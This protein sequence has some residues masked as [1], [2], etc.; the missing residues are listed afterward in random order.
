MN[1]VHGGCIIPMSVIVT[2]RCMRHSD[3][4][5]RLSLISATTMKRSMI[6]QSHGR[7]D[8]IVRFKI[9]SRLAVHELQLSCALWRGKCWWGA[10]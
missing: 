4:A 5:F 9:G 8:R 7:Y 2:S 1:Q 6:N 10:S 3:R